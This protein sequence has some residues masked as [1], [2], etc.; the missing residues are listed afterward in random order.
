MFV[1]LCLYL[2][3]GVHTGGT[4]EPHHHPLHPPFLCAPSCC[5]HRR[6]PAHVHRAGGW[7]G[8]HLLICWN[9]RQETWQLKGGCLCAVCHSTGL[10][11]MSVC[12]GTERERESVC[13]YV[14][15]CVCVCV[16]LRACFC[17]EKREKVVFRLVS[18]FRLF[19]NSQKR[20][21]RRRKKLDW[22]CLDC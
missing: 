19:F 6:L 4:A 18:R 7:S 20:R 14:C 21:R 5:Q 9:G 16:C 13:V 2:W 11:C 17:L 12:C 10:G 3:P 1:F 15:V 8:W 22:K